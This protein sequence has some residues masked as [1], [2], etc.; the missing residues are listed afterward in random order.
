MKRSFGA[1]FAAIAENPL[2]LF[3]GVV[4]LFLLI[5]FNEKLGLIYSFMLIFDWMFIISNK[6]NYPF[7]KDTFRAKDWLFAITAVVVFYFSSTIIVTIVQGL[8][9]FGS[10]LAS[11]FSKLAATTPILSES[12][13]LAFIGWG[14]LIPI[15]E[16]RFFFGRLLE[17]ML[18]SFRANLT[19]SSIKSHLIYAFVSAVFAG[20][21]ISARAVSKTQFD[22]SA[23]IM[24]FTFG[25]ISCLL[26]V[27]TKELASA[28]YFHVINNSVSTYNMLGGRFFASLFG[29]E[30]VVPR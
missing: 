24:T 27:L 20:F 4:L 26:V 7:E 29:F 18:R 22:T 23:M 28:T 3:L 1:L 16:T 2:T 21:H 13:I 6:P 15:I 10:P 5:N 19:L 11:V 17:S 14:I 12:N 25:Y 8:A 9:S 30:A